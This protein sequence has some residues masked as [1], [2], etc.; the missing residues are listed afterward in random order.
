LQGDIAIE[1]AAAQ[2]YCELLRIEEI[3][4]NDL[5]LHGIYARWFDKLVVEEIW[6]I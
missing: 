6:S 2:E 3:R 5:D 1:E 4:R